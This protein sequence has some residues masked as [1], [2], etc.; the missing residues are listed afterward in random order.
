MVLSP[1][2]PRKVRAVTP[3]LRVKHIFE[4]RLAMA[5]ILC[6][7]PTPGHLCKSCCEQ[8]Y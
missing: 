5:A 4:A 3:E 8:A 7:A 2:G 6:G 1:M